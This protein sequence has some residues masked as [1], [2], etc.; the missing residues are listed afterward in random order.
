MHDALQ[1]RGKI[2]Y[3]PYSEEKRK[4]LAENLRE[5]VNGER[6]L[7]DVEIINVRNV[8]ELLLQFKSITRQAKSDAYQDIKLEM[9]TQGIDLEQ[10]T[11]SKSGAAA[12]AST[13]TSAPQTGTLK[14]AVDPKTG[15]PLP[16]PAAPAQTAPLQPQLVGVIDSKSGFGLGVA[17]D[18]VPFNL[19]IFFFFNFFFFF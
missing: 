16:A 9:K 10:T 6:E 5:Y 17:P 15:K 8:K 1:G 19:N 2:Q 11:T 4:E 14:Q 13:A 7:D 18:G 12:V 3:D